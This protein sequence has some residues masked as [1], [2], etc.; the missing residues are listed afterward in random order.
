MKK[1]LLILLWLPFFSVGQSKKELKEMVVQYQDT[2]TIFSATTDALR[3]DI[4]ELQTQVS[5]LNKENNTQKKNKTRLLEEKERLTEKINLFKQEESINQDEIKTLKDEIKTLDFQIQT[6]G[7]SIQVLHALI[8]KGRFVNDSLRNLKIH[9]I[10]S[11]KDIISNSNF[12]KQNLIGVWDFKTLAW[13]TGSEYIDF[14]NV[15]SY[16]QN[17]YTNF[18]YDVDESVINKITLMDPNL[19]IIELSDGTKISCLFEIKKEGTPSRYKKNINI[20]FVDT[21]ASKFEITISEYGGT[22]IYNYDFNSLI[23]FFNRDGVRNPRISGVKYED[24]W[25][26]LRGGRL[27]GVIE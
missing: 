7:D 23:G 19:S 18:A 5:D 14:D 16:E 22:Y 25:N 17:S 6:L 13:I 24:Q 4:L 26:F 20:T 11:M 9:N 12:S 15:Y 10:I 8:D 1:L 2:I 27:I 3:D 21:D